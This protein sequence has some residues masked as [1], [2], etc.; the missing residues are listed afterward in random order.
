MLLIARTAVFFL[1]LIVL[2]SSSHAQRTYGVSQPGTGGIAPEISCQ[3]AFMGRADFGISVKGGLGGS[4]AYLALAAADST[5]TQSGIP[6]NIDPASLLLLTSMTLGGSSGVAGDGTG[7]F[8]VP[9]SMPVMSAFAGVHFFAQVIIVDPGAGGLASSTGL[10]VTLTMP[11]LIHGATSVSGSCDPHALIDPATSAVTMQSFCA[12]NVAAGSACFANNGLDLFVASS[13]SNRIEHCDLR[14]S[15][16]SWTTLVNLP[17]MPI[18]ARFDEEQQWL[19]TLEAASGTQRE[20]VAID[21]NGVVQASTAG[22]SGGGLVEIWT[23]SPSGKLAA[24]SSVLQPTI[25]LWDTDSSSPT[26]LQSIATLASPSSLGSSIRINT[27]MEFSPDGESLFVSIQNIGTTPGELARYSFSLGQWIDH[28]FTTPV[29]D[30]I[31]PAS[32]PPVPLGSAPR[33][34]SLGRDTNTVFLSGFGGS[35][36]AARVDY[37]PTNPFVFSGFLATG[38]GLNDASRCAV[39][40]D[41]TSL[42]VSATS[43]SRLILLDTTTMTPT[44]IM[45]TPLF[46]GTIGSLVWR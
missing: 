24:V 18:G 29:V 7:F 5:G 39:N 35:G 3:Q 38:V 32:V 46:S 44:S 21:T 30:N 22:L 2:V 13:L 36:W 27:C 41:G 4:T 43:P 12:N 15:T 40:S 45:T 33:G 17:G 16:P 42:A 31:G 20:L 25:K 14:G 19:W 34:L 9:L 37:S 8:A 1:L 10:E 6:T 11:P 28:D 26:F 23:L